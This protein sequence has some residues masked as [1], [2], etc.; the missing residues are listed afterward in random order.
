MHERTLALVSDIHGN[1]LALEAVLAEIARRGVTE[2]INLG[3]TLYGPLDPCGAY[4]RLRRS[5]GSIRHIAGNGDRIL[6]EDAR[7]NPTVAYTLQCLPQKALDWIK[8][9]PAT[10]VDAD[11]FACHGSPA[12]DTEYL[13]EDASRGGGALRHTAAIAKA[14]EGIKQ[15]LVL[16]GH[17][18]MPRA[19]YLPGGALVVNPGSVGLPAYRAE[20]PVPHVMESGAPHAVFAI[21]AKSGASWRVEHIRVP[22]DWQAAAQLAERNGRPD[23]AVALA[24]GRA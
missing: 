22:Y 23:W 1:S 20:S 14:V 13:L 4:D 19:A 8:N 24:T 7:G 3:D 18:H 15:K 16:C 2:I 11:V 10:F 9:L 17:S 6:L 5:S 12:S 21:V